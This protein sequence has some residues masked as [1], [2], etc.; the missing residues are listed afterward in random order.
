MNKHNY[1]TFFAKLSNPLRIDILS[2]LEDGE[3][4]VSELVS[5]LKIEQSK[6]SHALKELKEC[7]IVQSKPKGKKRLYNL[8]PTIKPILKLID[9]HSTRWCDCKECTGCAEIKK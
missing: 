6:L 4:S 8:S 9:H 3:K 5:E 7:N 2:C 1:H